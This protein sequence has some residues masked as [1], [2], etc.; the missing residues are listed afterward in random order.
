MKIRLIFNIFILTLLVSCTNNQEGKQKENG[1]G[2][3]IIESGE[4]ASV[5]TRSVVMPR[6]GRFWYS[7]KITGILN[8]G[9]VVKKGDSILQLDGTEIKK[10]II[11]RETQFAT[12]KAVLEK[13]KVDQANRVLDLQ[14][15]LK[16]EIASFELKNLEVES[17]RFDTEKNRKV[18]LIEFEQAKLN[19]K[20][21]KHS[22]DLNKRIA[23][24]TLQI[25][26]IKTDQLN[27][28]IKDAYA[29]LPKL[30][31]RAPISGI[32]QVAVNRRTG[33]PVKIG[34]E[35][36]QGNMLGSVPDL[37][38]MKV[39]TSV[40]EIDYL[41]IKIGQKVQVRMDALPK[42]VFMG[43][44]NYLGKLCHRKDDK[45]K[46]KVFD[47]EVKILKP[48]NRLKPGMTVSCEYI[49]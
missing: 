9:T 37:T 46:E 42:V 7:M 6:F 27:N 25:E 32:F 3:K 16:S 26:Q 13:L 1:S 4:L 12:Q 10:Y 33:T 5:E 15:R 34:D 20:K 19:L 38:W 18:K 2:S 35:I 21:V 40:N 17:S 28:E 14:S 48:D 49:P 39:N 8:H 44:V 29:I 47:V 43:E 24:Y 11:E 23:A 45:S 36:Y 22:I 41:K 30:T 31:L